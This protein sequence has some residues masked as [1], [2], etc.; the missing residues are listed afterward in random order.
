[1]TKDAEGKEK[2]ERH[3][4][5]EV[6]TKENGRCLLLS[7]TGGPEFHDKEY[8]GTLAVPLLNTPLSVDVS[9]PVSCKSVTLLR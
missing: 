8:P 2:D 7:A 6:W 1:L 5:S 4:W 9:R 3:R